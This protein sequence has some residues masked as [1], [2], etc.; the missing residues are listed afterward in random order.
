[1][2]RGLMYRLKIFRPRWPTCVLIRG[3]VIT[4]SNLFNTSS[5]SLFLI[6][7]DHIIRLASLSLR[8]SHFNSQKRDLPRDHFQVFRILPPCYPHLAPPQ[9]TTKWNIVV[10]QRGSTWHDLWSLSTYAPRARHLYNAV[11]LGIHL[12]PQDTDSPPPQESKHVQLILSHV[13]FFPA[14]LARGRHPGV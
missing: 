5:L 6:K 13:P 11:A 10:S 7:R 2:H 12:R 1:M 14:S 8:S 9:G 4:C 3:K